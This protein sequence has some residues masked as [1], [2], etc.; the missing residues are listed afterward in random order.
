[1]STKVPKTYFYKFYDASGTYQSEFYGQ[2]F[3]V[4]SLPEFTWRINGGKGS[5]EIKIAGSATDFQN[6][7]SQNSNFKMEVYVHDKETPARGQ[8]IYTGHNIDSTYRLMNNGFIELEPLLYI[9]GEKDLNNKYVENLVTGATTISY[10]NED[11]AD[12]IRDLLDKYAL[13]G[14]YVTYDSESIVDTGF[15]ISLTVKNEFYLE[16]INRIVGYLPRFWHWYIDGENKFNLRKT[17]FDVVDHKL[18]IGREVIGGQIR[19]SFGEMVNGVYFHGGDTGG[20]TK[21]Y[22]KYTNATS[23]TSF[24]VFDRTISDERVTDPNTAEI[25]AQAMLDDGSS[26]I[27][28]V[29]ME[30]IDSNGSA[31]GYD[32]ESIKPGDTIQ[33]LSS[34]VATQF[35]YWQ[36]DAGT[37][38]NGV[39][40]VS[41]WDYDIDASLGVPFQVQ[42]IQYQHDRVV[43]RASDIIQD[44]STTVDQLEKRQFLAETVDSPTSP[45]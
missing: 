2:G 21:L 6:Y 43:V 11:P 33:A 15:S 23:Q 31:N 25:R 42:E 41:F 5:Q 28:Y 10:S 12:I 18:Y 37:V 3:D 22:K 30:I 20:G 26:P 24:G 9:S 45:S 44:L 14:G 16:A 36:N 1:M 13:K 35:T 17:N 27:R 7:A 32:I 40:D 39:W 29:E 38:G 4:A 19:L 34:D 8:L